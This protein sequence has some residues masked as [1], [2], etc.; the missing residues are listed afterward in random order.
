MYLY[1]NSVV[2]RVEDS[3]LIEER[4]VLHL[5]IPPYCKMNNQK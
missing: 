5:R 2:E 1:L 4:E 3:R